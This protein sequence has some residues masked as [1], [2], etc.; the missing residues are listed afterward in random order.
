[1]FLEIVV[2]KCKLPD[3]L[4]DWECNSPINLDICIDDNN[5]EN[6]FVH[7]SYCY[8]ICKYCIEEEFNVVKLKG[9]SLYFILRNEEVFEIFN[10]LYF[11]YLSI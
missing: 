7:V 5:I 10:I 6:Q 3:L 2:A 8:V 9:W 1:M 4:N 11:L